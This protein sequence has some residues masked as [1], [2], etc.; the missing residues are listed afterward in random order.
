MF[1]N[2]LN[3]SNHPTGWSGWCIVGS[4]PRQRHGLWVVPWPKP[5]SNIHPVDDVCDLTRTSVAASTPPRCP[6]RGRFTYEDV[7]LLSRA[8]PSWS[9]SEVGGVIG[10]GR[11]GVVVRS[12]GRGGEQGL[13]GSLHVMSSRDVDGRLLYC[14][15]LRY[16][17]RGLVS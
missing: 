13:A 3:E 8:G 15:N 12:I 14:R 7:K 16:E 10:V 5:R 17:A 11:G 2:K 6:Q 1:S 9:G 4:W